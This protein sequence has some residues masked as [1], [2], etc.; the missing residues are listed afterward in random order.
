MDTSNEQSPKTWGG[1]HQGAGRKRKGVKRVVFCAS[2]EAVDVLEAV[3]GNKSDFINE[4]IVRAGKAM[5]R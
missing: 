1:A 5:R 2:Q 4:C 3:G